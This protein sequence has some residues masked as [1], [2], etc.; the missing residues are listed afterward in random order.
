M[1]RK[2]LSCADTAALLRQALKE[3]FPG[4]KFSVK[5]KTYSGGAS[6]SVRWVDGPAGALV[7][8]VVDRFEGAYFDGMID[9][10]GSCYHKLDG[11]DVHFGADFIF[12]DRDYSDA[13]IL[14]AYDLIAR[15]YSG[16]WA[17]LKDKPSVEDY[18][19][20][21]LYNVEFIPG[22]MRGDDLQRLVGMTLAKISD[23]AMPS[24]SAT[25]KR[26]SFAGDDGYGRGTVGSDPA[27][28]DGESC[29][30]AISAAQDRQAAKAALS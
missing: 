21:R 25:L 29:Y 13:M 9:Y 18:R 1:S 16:N 30:K 17:M 15:K 3:S 7:K 10:K 28:P 26:V 20:G 8:S 2:Y 11:V 6:I 23:R 14:R 4:V 24:D 22:S 27:N 5:S 12:T 19:M